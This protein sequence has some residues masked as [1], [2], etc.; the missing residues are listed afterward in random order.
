MLN[1]KRGCSKCGLNLNNKRQVRGKSGVTMPNVH[2]TQVNL[3]LHLPSTYVTRNT[4]SFAMHYIY[5]LISS[6]AEM[7]GEKSGWPRFL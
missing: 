6:R 5:S 4:F 2:G 3:S 1:F 7:S